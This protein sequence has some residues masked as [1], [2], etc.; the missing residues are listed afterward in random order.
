MPFI[1]HVMLVG[2]VL[3]LMT[4]SRCVLIDYP[5]LFGILYLPLMFGTSLLNV[6]LF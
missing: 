5:F 3:F 2:G 1:I 6:Y 4:L